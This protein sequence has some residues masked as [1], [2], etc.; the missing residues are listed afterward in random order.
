[1]RATN[2]ACEGRG[3]AGW[4]IALTPRGWACALGALVLG[5]GWYAIGLR[6]V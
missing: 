6:D 3:A 2:G 1:M 5:V 4:S